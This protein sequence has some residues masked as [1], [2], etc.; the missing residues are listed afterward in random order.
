MISSDTLQADTVIIGAGFFGCAL[1]LHLVESK[2][3]KSVILLEQESDILLRASK[4][5]Q[6]RVHNG[7]HYPRSFTTAYRS[8]KNFPKFCLDFPEAIENNFN[9][10]YAVAKINS[11]V[12]AKQ[13]ERFCKEIGAEID[14][15]S[16]NYESLFENRLIE[17]AYHVKECAF[18]AVI[19]ANILRESLKKA[20]IQ[21]LL[22]TKA[23]S[24]TSTKEKGHSLKVWLNNSSIT[25]D[26]P[27]ILTNQVFNCAYSGINDVQGEFSTTQTKFKHE[28]AELALVELPETY[29]NIGITVVDGP[30]F[31]VMPYPAENLHTLSHVRYTP[32][33]SYLDEEG[34]SAYEGIKNFTKS[35]RVDRMIRDAKRYLPFI[36][37]CEYKKSIFELKTVLIRNEKDDGRPILFEKNQGLPNV[38]SVLGSKIDNVYDVFKALEGI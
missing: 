6:A 35:T 32:H 31:S 21:T 37:D 2:K 15:V 36:A 26:G 7:Y 25:N 12:S 20:N 29:R 22:S 9:K 3:S 4:I 34:K 38:Y 17:R 24:I 5:N 27:H 30:F 33:H 1:A 14:P 23:S 8:R 28:V 11:K 16:S 18:N 13:F 19:L 10:I